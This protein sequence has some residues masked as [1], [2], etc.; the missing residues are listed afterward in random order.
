ML[1]ASS[2]SPWTVPVVASPVPTGERPLAD[3]GRTVTAACGDAVNSSE[4]R[5]LAQRQAAHSASPNS[6]GSGPQLVTLAIGRSAKP[7]GGCTG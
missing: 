1:Q 7:S 3:G 2:T 4:R 5:R 6:S